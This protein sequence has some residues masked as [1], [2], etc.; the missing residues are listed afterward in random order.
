MVFNVTTALFSCDSMLFSFFPLS[1]CLLL[2]SPFLCVLKLLILIHPDVLRMTVHRS[3]RVGPRKEDR[4]KRCNISKQA[5]SQL[6]MHARCPTHRPALMSLSLLVNATAYLHTVI[7]ASRLRVSFSLRRGGALF[8]SS[9]SF[10]APGF[11]YTNWWPR[12]L[13]E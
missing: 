2:D 5:L 1:P 4:M 11:G 3:L 10:V 13:V 6:N 8:H 12:R 7:F 9:G